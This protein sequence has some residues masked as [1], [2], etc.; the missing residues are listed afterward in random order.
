MPFLID[1]PFLIKGQETKSSDLIAGYS[2]A[3]PAVVGKDYC[4]PSLSVLSKYWQDPSGRGQLK[5]DEWGIVAKRKYSS[6]TVFQCCHWP[7][8]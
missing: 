7:V 1:I 8:G 2:M 4:F 5:C 6:I 3:L